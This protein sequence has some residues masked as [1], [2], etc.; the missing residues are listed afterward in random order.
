[1]LKGRLKKKSVRN[2]KYNEPL[3]LKLVSLFLVCVFETFGSRVRAETERTVYGRES[4]FL[5]SS[6][7]M[8]RL[9]QPLS[10]VL[11]ASFCGSSPALNG[12]WALSGHG[13]IRTLTFRS[14]SSLARAPLL[15]CPP[16]PSPAGLSSE[17]E[18][19]LAAA[20]SWKSN[21]AL[22]FGQSLRSVEAIVVSL[23]PWF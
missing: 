8:K 1:M 11:S 18:A 7:V 23:L 13:H 3:K 5:R 6:R 15:S 12:S 4:E 17:W 2:S 21:F 20:V 22:I 19:A 9:N 14:F 16:F 10:A